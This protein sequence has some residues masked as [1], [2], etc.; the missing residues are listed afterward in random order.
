MKA[1]GIMGWG[2]KQE[3]GEVRR[4]MQRSGLK[5]RGKSPNFSLNSFLD[6]H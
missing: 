2:L 4:A 5:T 3:G 1:P 6:L